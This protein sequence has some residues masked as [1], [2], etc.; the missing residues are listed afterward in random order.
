MPTTPQRSDNP[1]AIS[2]QEDAADVLARRCRAHLSGACLVTENLSLQDVNPVEGLVSLVPHR[3]LAE[4]A[5]AWVED[6]D[7]P[8]P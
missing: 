3:P 7:W 1:V 6:V 5:R 4:S 2:S 8:A